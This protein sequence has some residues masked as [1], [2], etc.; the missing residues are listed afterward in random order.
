MSSQEF[1]VTAF[2]SRSKWKTWLEKN[3][4]TSAGLWLKIAKKDSGIA[5]VSYDDALAAALCYGWIDGQKK[6]CDDDH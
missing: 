5:T 1:P 6:S 3:H 2:A 4:T